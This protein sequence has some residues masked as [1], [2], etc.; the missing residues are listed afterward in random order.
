M[1]RYACWIRCLFVP[2]GILLG[3][4]L[5]VSCQVPGVSSTA[6]TPQ[7]EFRPERQAGLREPIILIPGTLGSRLYNIDNGEI[8]WGSL[9]A[10][11]SDLQ[12]DLSLP[13][14][15]PTLAE[16]RDRLRAYRVFDR[17]E[18]F[19]PEGSGE[20]RF[21]AE[22]TEYLESTLG[23]RPA[24]GNRFYPG[25][26]LFVFF[27]DWRRS[28][29]EA[30]QQLDQF[31]RDI[32]RDLDAPDMKFTFVAVSN[33]GIVARYY[34]RFGGR[35]VI[36]NLPVD[37]PLEPT[38]EGLNACKR[39]IC[40]GT[41]HTG[42][43][44]ALHLLHDG[45]VPNLISRRYPPETIF[46]FPA[47]FELLPDPGERI[48]VG[49][50]GE[51]LDFDLWDPQMWEDYGLSVFSRS[52]Q[53]RIRRNIIENIRPGEDRQELFDQRL[54]EQRRYLR[55]VMTHAE[56][57]K[58]AIDGPVGVPTH[59]IMGVQA[60]TLARAGMVNDGD[61]WQFFF[62]PQFSWGRYEPML[63]AMYSLGDGVVTR[64]SALGLPL[65][66]SP[67][68]LQQRGREFRDSLSGW[69]FTGMSHRNMFADPLLR[70]ALAELLIDP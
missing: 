69:T 32:R 42:T 47:A 14:D 49:E 43:M 17:A 29:V 31:I 20:V 53:G 33:G 45:Y 1:M 46:S 60:P 11:I 23:Y 28:N 6:V 19:A 16:N 50:A 9:A 54:D 58:R 30:A 35:D 57:L 10:T 24:Y 27:Y 25:Q 62:T 51:A 41:P 3:A 66:Q 8:A 55:L 52:E 40:L 63:Q 21:Y 4:L 38:W 56:R 12:D 26:D 5:V 39:L 64:R 59:S 34:L 18:I 2:A 68:P 37:A 22:I 67:E 36:S 48:F 7:I 65:A 13:I 15:R 61:R 70:L 44:D